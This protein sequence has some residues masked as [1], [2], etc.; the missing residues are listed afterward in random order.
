MQI[1]RFHNL[2]SLGSYEWIYFDLISDNHDY[3]LIVIFYNGFPFYN[4]YLK[5]Y[6]DN[7]KSIIKDKLT[8]LDFPAISLCI[9]EKNK[10]LA[11][12]HYIFNKDSLVINENTIAYSNN[13]ILIR[14]DNYNYSLHFKLKFP[15]RKLKLIGDLRISNSDV[16][17][18]ELII[19]KESEKHFWKNNLIKFYGAADISI[20]RHDVLKKRISFS[21]IGY[22]DHNWGVRPIPVDIKN[23]YWGRFHKGEYT[24][25]YLIT[26]SFNNTTSKYFAFYKGNHCI[27]DSTNFELKKSEC[28]N[29]FFLKY[30]KLLM[31]YDNNFSA[32]NINNIKLDN[33][34]FYIRFLSKFK[35]KHSELRLD[36][37]GISEYI[38]PP[39]LLKSFFNP[40]IN[41]KIKKY[42]P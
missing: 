34:P 25:F 26:E 30:D 18:K 6:F 3:S 1:N 14:N 21:G 39:R 37:I 22:N 23:W 7:I 15:Y 19:E 5:N 32:E 24:F 20:Y 27:I 38:H 9:Y 16:S 12:L 28:Y 8:A 31:I 33:G 10:K 40:F 36:G 35:I 29:Y 41:L 11:N 4:K 2:D 13:A 17:T 42:Q